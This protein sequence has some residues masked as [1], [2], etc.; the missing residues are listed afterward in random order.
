MPAR[1]GRWRIAHVERIGIAKIQQAGGARLTLL[2]GVIAAIA[3][4]VGNVLSLHAEG[5]LAG[6][7]RSTGE[8]RCCAQN[9]G[10]EKRRSHLS[11]RVGRLA[12]VIRISWFDSNICMPLQQTLL[13]MAESKARQQP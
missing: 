12:A 5:P 7:S 4:R 9:K 2:V 13:Q 6:L 3:V 8:S 1:L 10:R 11:L